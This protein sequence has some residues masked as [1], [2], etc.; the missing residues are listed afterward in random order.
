VGRGRGRKG[1]RGL[2]NGREGGDA[3]RT[4]RLG[5]G[6]RGLVRR[7]PGGIAGGVPRGCRL[8]SRGKSGRGSVSISGSRSLDRRRPRGRANAD[9]FCRVDLPEEL[10][11]G[12]RG[13]QRIAERV[14]CPVAFLRAASRQREVPIG[15]TSIV[16]RASSIR[17][18]F[19][20]QRP[21]ERREDVV[22]AGGR[23]GGSRRDAR[24]RCR[25][26]WGLN[27]QSH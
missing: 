7:V 16:R 23:I 13:R 18:K 20:E 19:A 1:C 2:F 4:S 27:D 11:G 17:G 14:V 26:G 25:V 10:K 9:G 22:G 21:K 12:N 5:G 3:G 15:G 24:Q 8:E 6:H